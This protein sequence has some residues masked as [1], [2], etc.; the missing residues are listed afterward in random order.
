MNYKQF[1]VI[2]SVWTVIT[3]TPILDTKNIKTYTD[4]SKHFKKSNKNRVYTQTP[5]TH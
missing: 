2:H 1:I 4:N 3:S 5:S